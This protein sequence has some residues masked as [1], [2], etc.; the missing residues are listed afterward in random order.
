MQSIADILE[1]LNL[2]HHTLLFLGIIGLI[3]LRLIYLLRRPTAN[4]PSLALG[5]KRTLMLG[6]AV[7][8]LF[9]F[10]MFLF[11]ALKPT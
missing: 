5:E 8:L 9:F 7:L 1:G 3:L 2:L 10:V 6:L 11:A 4:P